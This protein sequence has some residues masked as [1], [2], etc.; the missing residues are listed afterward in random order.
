VLLRLREAEVDGLGSMTTLDPRPTIL[1]KVLAQEGRIM[2]V[3]PH[4]PEYTHT[5]GEEA[6]APARAQALPSRF[7][8]E[9]RRWRP[10]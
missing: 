2:I 10:C 8:R 5:P 3:M 9:G 1:P 4:D 7:V 6:P